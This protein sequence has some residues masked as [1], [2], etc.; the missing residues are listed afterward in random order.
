VAGEVQ[1][2]PAPGLHLEGLVYASLPERGP[3]IPPLLSLYIDPP[4]GSVLRRN[5]GK[6]ID[7]TAR[8]T[9]DPD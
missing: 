2:N 5:E 8:R 9:A 6:T 1:A 4:T 7:Q 3:V